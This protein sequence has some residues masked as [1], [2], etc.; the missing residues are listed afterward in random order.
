M[1]L[2]EVSSANVT[3]IVAFG[4][5]VISILSPCVLPMVPGYIAL[6]TGLEVRDVQ[7]G[8][9][10]DLGRIAAMTGWFALGF[11]AVFVLL[12]LA[13]STVGQ[14]LFDNQELLTRI[15]GAVVLVMAL[16]L[17]GS[18]VLMA[19]RLYGESRFHV[20][21]G[22]FGMFTAPVAGAAFAFGWSPCLGPIIAAVFGVA[23][24][25]T[26]PRAVLL[27][28]SYSAGMAVSFLAVGLAFGR[29]AAP[30]EFVKRHLRTL[31]FVS[32]GVLAVFGVLLLLD[33]MWMLSSWLTR[34]LDALGLDRLVELG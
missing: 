11:S 26:G 6:V 7:A 28:A 21:S 2:G 25:E 22:Q 34:V 27:L 16:Y 4:G 24:T 8:R 10:R 9:A 13:A 33:R 29:W 30:L 18:Q 23:A 14:S 19:P 12:G 1:V 5:G 3:M 31:T 17:A 20:R 15:S 32:A